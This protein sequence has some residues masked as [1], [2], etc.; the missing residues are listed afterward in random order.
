MVVSHPIDNGQWFNFDITVLT[1]MKN[2]H[3][4]CFISNMVYEK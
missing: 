4:F 1:K 2:N 3:H